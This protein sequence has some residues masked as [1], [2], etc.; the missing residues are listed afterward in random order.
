METEPTQF[1]VLTPGG[2]GFA[3]DP[4]DPPGTIDMWAVAW[5]NHNGPKCVFC[6]ESWCHHCDDSWRQGLCDKTPTVIKENADA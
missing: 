4:E 2:H 3:V 5:D 6:N 1:L